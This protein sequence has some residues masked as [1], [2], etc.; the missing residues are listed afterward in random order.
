MG[1]MRH[2]SFSA[3]VGSGRPAPELLL[4]HVEKLLAAILAEHDPPGNK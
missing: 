3:S 2:V 4:P 1:F